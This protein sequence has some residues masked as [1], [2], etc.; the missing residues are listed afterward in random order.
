MTFPL[1]NSSFELS[2]KIF[3]DSLTNDL[4]HQFL[5]SY[6]L[7]QTNSDTNVTTHFWVSS[8]NHITTIL[9]FYFSSDCNKPLCLQPRNV[10]I[11]RE[12]LECSAYYSS[13][14]CTSILFDNLK[15]QEL[16]A[17][18]LGDLIASYQA[19]VLNVLIIFNLSFSAYG[20]IPNIS[21]KIQKR[22]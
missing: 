5:L 4:I 18:S 13:R 11:V 17:G 15:K 14:Q 16:H 19:V 20:N 7:K 22:W 10:V 12:N 21:T 9:F 6:A 3:V 8:T 2:Y 1:V